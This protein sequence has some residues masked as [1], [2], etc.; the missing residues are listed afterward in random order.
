MFLLYSFTMVL[1]FHSPFMAGRLLCTRSWLQTY[2]ATDWGSSVE[3]RVPERMPLVIPPYGKGIP[4]SE[5][6]LQKYGK[7]NDTGFQREFVG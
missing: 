2:F 4:P 3:M 6:L 1:D 5:Y 7:S